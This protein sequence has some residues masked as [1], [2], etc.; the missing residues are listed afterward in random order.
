MKKISLTI[1]FIIT[2][3]VSIYGQ[4]TTPKIRFG[5]RV[6]AGLGKVA[7]EKFVSSVTN[8]DAQRLKYTNAL[9]LGIVSEMNLKDN[10]AIQ[11][12]LGY[13]LR[14][15]VGENTFGSS[16]AGMVVSEVT[17]TY[18]IIELPVLA[19][20]KF[21]GL[22][23]TAG[24][25]LQYILS[26]NKLKN[27]ATPSGFSTIDGDYIT[28]DVSSLKF[29]FGGGIGYQS[30]KIFVEAR[31]NWIPSKTINNSIYGNSLALDSNI[32]FGVNLGY[33]FK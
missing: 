20:L 31:G 18:N 8:Y 7:S 11:A 5:L 6:G 21:N 14:G 28:S 33:F 4:I 24:P 32:S 29:G 12:E 25:Q 30:G 19:K 3:L 26:A 16:A 13:A 1:S 27:L 9:G 22:Y 17:G 15:S 10:F 23:L 2:S